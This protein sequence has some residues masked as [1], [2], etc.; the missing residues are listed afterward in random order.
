MTTRG[1]RVRRASGY[2]PGD[3]IRC[4]NSKSVPNPYKPFNYSSCSLHYTMNTTHS[5]KERREEVNKEINPFYV[6]STNAYCLLDNNLFVI[7]INESIQSWICPVFWASPVQSSLPGINIQCIR[8]FGPA[9][10]LILSGAL[11]KP[12]TIV[13]YS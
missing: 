7:N 8:L 9:D 5:V 4:Q 11:G 1:G 10:Y 3:L 2:D 6:H 12:C 13:M